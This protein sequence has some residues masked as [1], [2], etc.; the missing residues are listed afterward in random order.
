MLDG[1][2][3]SS[4]LWRVDQPLAQEIENGSSDFLSSDVCRDDCNVDEAPKSRGADYGYLRLGF[5]VI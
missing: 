4:W 5:V 2:H 3:K 1:T